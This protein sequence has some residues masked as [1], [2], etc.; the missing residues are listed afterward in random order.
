MDITEHKKAD[1]ESE[2]H[3]MHLEELVK[4][5]T[6]ELTKVNE[7]LQKEIE[8]LKHTETGIKSSEERLKI[9]FEYAPDAYYLSDLKGYFIDGNKAAEHLIGYKRDELIGKSFLKLKLLPPKQITKAAKLLAK[10]AIGKPTGP[11]EF[12]IIRKDGNQVPVEIRTFPI[13]IENKSLVLG[14]ARDI[15]ER[16]HT[17]EVLKESEEKFRTLAEQSPN[18]IFVNKKGRVVYANKKCEEI[19]GF[20][21]EE[22]YSPDFNFLTLIAPEYTDLVKANFSMHIKGEDVLTYEYALISKKGDRIEVINAP[23]LIRYEGESAILGIVTD[24]TQ[25][26]HAEVELIKHRDHLEELVEERTVELKRKNKQLQREIT[27][28]QRM[29]EELRKAEERVRDFIES[30][31]DMV[32]FKSLDGT[33]SM[34]NEANARITGYTREEF[35]ANPQ[36]WRKIVHPDDLKMA[37]EFFV[38]NPEGMASFDMEYRLRTKSGEWRWI[39]SHMAGVKDN[40]GQYI[41]YNCV[42]RDITEHKQAEKEKTKIQGQLFQAQKMDAIG[43]LTSGIAHDFNNL[44]T[45]ILVCTDTAILNINKENPIY[46]ELSATRDAAQR[47]SDLIRQLLLFSRKHPMELML[48]D[49]D[50]LVENLLNMLHRIIGEDIV[51]N[52]NLAQDHLTVLIDQGTIEQV[53]MNLA[54]NAKEAMPGGGKLKIRTEKVLLDEKDCKNMLEARPGLFVCLTME[55]NG[56]GMN[57]VTMQHIFEP[58][59]STKGPR[60]GTGLG[61]SVV[62][63]IVKQHEG[64]IVVDSKPGEG[65][66]FKIYLPLSSV[67]PEDEMEKLISMMESKGCGER[68]L[69]VEDE[70]LIRE[71]T[72]RALSKYG[73]VVFGASNA[74]EALDIFNEEQNNF[75]LIFSDVALPDKSGIELV[76]DFLSRNPDLQILMSSGYTDQKSNWRSIQ[77]RGFRYLQKPYELADLLHTV[78]GVLKEVKHEG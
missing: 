46:D 1:E 37:D 76:D 75:D 54:V 4:E 40:S 24:I 55:D 66:S 12:N 56:I 68:I 34:L 32:Y 58:Y 17:E 57:R 63:G 26:K 42:D 21:R 48:V 6:A 3:R 78:E 52:T 74:N 41:G 20:K 18:M 70:K 33:I 29:E 13:K 28:R 71:F 2:T 36:L 50:K 30:V 31:D 64:W 27:R 19:M 7:K 10:N 39:Q 9:L 14:I 77:E 38:E 35:A 72:G 5:R 59:F 43:S 25:R 61:L 15:T 65:T 53:I 73:Y 16:K 69:L 49:L 47:A 23:K 22:F 60:K 51:I 44:M 8:K 67:Q 45:A 11:D 62:Y